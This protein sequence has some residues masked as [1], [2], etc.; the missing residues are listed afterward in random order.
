MGLSNVQ[1]Q[2]RRHRS[3]IFPRKA[4]HRRES[5]GEVGLTSCGSSLL[6]PLHLQFPFEALKF[7]MSWFDVISSMVCW[8][9]HHFCT[10]SQWIYT[11][12]MDNDTQFIADH[13][14]LD[15]PSLKPPGH[16]EFPA[17]LADPMFDLTSSKSAMSHLAFV[18][19]SVAQRACN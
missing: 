8:K 10:M 1:K 18:S 17:K 13:P 6:Q 15:V 11:I 16:G 9:I 3:F 7:Q 12:I 2:H 14:K 5:A 19:A 4:R